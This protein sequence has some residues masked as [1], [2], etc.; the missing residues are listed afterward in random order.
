MVQKKTGLVDCA[1]QSSQVQQQKCSLLKTQTWLH[2]LKTAGFYLL[3]NQWT[4]KTDRDMDLLDACTSLINMFL[5]P[6]CMMGAQ[7]D[8][9]TF[10]YALFTRLDLRV[11]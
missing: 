2:E 7:I 8:F 10:P 9:K 6:F 4:G 5:F 11:P 1:D 3:S